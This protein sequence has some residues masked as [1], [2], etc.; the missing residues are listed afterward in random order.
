MDSL[1]PQLL[2]FPPH[3]PPLLPLPDVEVDRGLRRI[4]KLLN[5]L[6]AKKLTAGLSG[7]GGGDLLEVC[8]VIVFQEQS[9]LFALV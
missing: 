4:V 6:P 5:E 9:W 8:D 2:A 3:P 7:G 1:L